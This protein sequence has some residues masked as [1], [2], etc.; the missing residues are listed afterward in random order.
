[1]WPRCQQVRSKWIRSRIL[2]PR[3]WWLLMILD[4]TMMIY[5]SLNQS[6]SPEIRVLS[7]L[8]NSQMHFLATTNNT[9]L[10]SVKTLISHLLNIFRTIAPSWI[11]NCQTFLIVI[12]FKWHNLFLRF[13]RCN[14]WMEI[15]P[16]KK[17]YRKMCLQSCWTMNKPKINTA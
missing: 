17:T 3:D 7:I 11:T 4:W 10:Y 5:F 16:N 13:Q 1:M 6:N 15:K 12:P 9:T 14:S 8:V 2:C